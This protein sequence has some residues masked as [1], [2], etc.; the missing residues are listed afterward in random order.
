MNGDAITDSYPWES[1]EADWDSDE[2][3]ADEIGEDIE[4]IGEA[5]RKRRQRHSP[6]RRMQGVQG[7]RL[8]GQDGRPQT[9]KFPSNVARVDET[10][11][12]LARQE[13]GRRELEEKLTRLERQFGRQLKKDS[14]ITGFVTLVTGGAL[15]AYGAIKAQPDQPDTNDTKLKSW[16][17]N[18]ATRMASLISATQLATSG[19]KLVINGRYDRSG[20]GI[21]A[22]IFAVGQLATFVFG[23]FSSSGAFNVPKPV[24]IVPNETALIPSN[25]YDGAI[26]LIAQRHQLVQVVNSHGIWDFYP[27]SESISQTTNGQANPQTTTG[28]ANPQTNPKHG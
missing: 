16:T 10:N 18:E 1:G 11:Q 22:D 15:T 12:A 26:I 4:D 27:L 8:Q 9:L 23:T 13:M 28:Q 24:A 19:A 17:K 20:L 7:V 2:S 21:A 25:Y 5:R 3:F 6:Y 14:S